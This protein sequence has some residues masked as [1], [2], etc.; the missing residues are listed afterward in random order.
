MSGPIQKGI[1][2]ALKAL[3]NAKS[4]T[5][6]LLHP[7]PDLSNWENAV[8]LEAQFDRVVK[9]IRS[10]EMQMDSLRDSSNAWIEL[11]ARLIG[12][13]KDNGEKEYVKFD[14]NEKIAERYDAATTKLRDLRDLEATLS[15]AAKLHKGRA[16]REAKA[17]QL[18]NPQQQAPMPPAM[19]APMAAPTFTA[20]LYQFQPI[21]LDKFFGQK[22]KW[23]EF[24]ESFKSAIGSQSISKAQKLN[25]LLNLLGGEAREL[26]AGF[27]LEDA[28]YET[29]LQLLKDTYGAPEEHIRSLH[30]ELANLKPCRGLRET[31]DFL[32]QL[33]R[34]TRELNN[35]GEDIEGPQVFLMLEKKLTPA[36]LRNILN[37]KGEDPANWTTTKFRD[38][39]N[40]A[41][42]KEVQIQEVLGEYGHHHQSI[43]RPARPA[44]QAQAPR[45][46][47]FAANFRNRN[48]TPAIRERTFMS[49]TIEEVHKR[50]NHNKPQLRKSQPRG[51]RPTQ[52]PSTVP[53][54]NGTA[55]QAGPRKPPS[56]CLFCNGNHWNEECQR[57]NTVQQRSAFVRDKGLCF[58]CL[59]SNHRASEC[60]RPIKCYK[61]RQ[62]HPAILCQEGT[63]AATQ[64]Q[65]AAAVT[66]RH[67]NQDEQKSTNPTA[68]SMSNAVQS[69][70]TRALL[71]TTMATIFNP[72]RP[73]Q[74]M[75][76]TVF[77]DPG[78]H[79]SFISN[80]AAKQLELTVLRTEECFLTSFGEREPKRYVS[81]RVA[82][83]FL[84]PNGDRLI[85]NLNALKFLLNNLPVLQLNTLDKQQLQQKKLFP[86]HESRQPDVMLGMDVWHDLHV[87]PIERLPSGFTIC[88]SKIGKIISGTGRIELSQPSNV[89]FVLTVT[90]ENVFTTEEDLK[91]NE[92]LNKFYGLNII[93]M[94]DSSTP[95]DRDEVMKNF[96]EN[97]SFVNNKYQIALPWND[98]VAQ[99]PTNY[100][101]AKAR[102]ISLIR[103]LRTIN[104]VDEYQ[105]ILDEQQQNSIIELVNSDHSCGPVHYLPHR[106]VIR[107]D[108]STT[109]IRIVMDASA[110]PKSTP[111]APSLNECL[112]TGPLLLK[113]LTGI[114]LRF[115]RMEKVILADIEKAFLQLGVREQDRDATRFLWLA[116]P[117]EANLEQL[118]REDFRVFRFCR[119]S[120]GLTV[121]PFLLNATLRE[122]LALYDTDVAQR[123]SDNLY[124]DNIMMEVTPSENITQLITEAKIIFESAGMRIREFFGSHIDEL[125]ELDSS[126]LA[127][128][129]ENT[130]VL[131]IEWKP[132]HDQ[133]IFKMPIFSSPTTKRKILSHIAKVYDPL[134]L[135]SPAL[136]P[137]KHF[138]QIVQN[139]NFKWDDP[140]PEKMALDWI[141]LMQAW[142]GFGFNFR[143]EFPRHIATSPS[144]EFHCFCDASKSGLGV[145]LYQLADTSYGKKES[146]LI[147]GKS[148]V[149][150]LKVADHDSTIPK[151][152]LQALTLGVKVTKF[153]Q[154][155]LNFNDQQVVLWTDSQCS[156]ERLKEERKYDRFVSNRLKKIREARFKVMHIRTDENPA[157]IASRGTDPQSL[158]SSLL[159]RFGPAW[160]TKVSQWPESNVTY[161]PGEE[162]REVTEPPIVEWS[163][164]VQQREEFVPAIQFERFSNWNRLRATAAHVIRFAVTMLQKRQN[165][166]PTNSP[167]LTHGYQS[168][169]GPLTANE[170]EIADE[171]MLIE[172]QLQHWPSESVINN[173]KL[174][175]SKPLE[176]LKCQG[177]LG[178]ANLPIQSKN[179]IFLPAEAWT[180][181]L[182]IVHYDRI[183]KHCGPRILLSKIR[184]K[185]WI[186]RG[187]QTVQNALYSSRIGCLAC[188]KEKLKPYAYP[189]APNL[190]KER[191][192]ETRPF[193]NTGI[194]YF[195]PLK[196]KR[197]PETVKVYV[198]LFTCLVI[199]AIH[200]EVADDYSAEAF[201]RVFRRFAAR[202]GVPRVILSDQGTNFIAGAKVIKENWTTDLLTL[203]VQEQLAHQGITWNFNTAHAPWKGGTWER[204]I[205]ITKNA[206][207]RSIGRRLL[208]FDEFGTLVVEIEA[209]VNHRPLTFESDREPDPVLRPV[210]FLIPYGSTETNFP[211]M[212]TDPEDPEYQP[213]PNKLK[214]MLQKADSRLNS[215][216][217]IWRSEYLLSLRE[218]AN[219]RLNNEQQTPNEGDIVLVEEE[220]NPR[221]VWSLARVLKVQIGRDNKSRSALISHN[222]KEKWR[223]VNQLYSLEIQPE[224]PE[225][226]FT[227]FVMSN[228][229]ND[230]DSVSLAG[231]E[232]E[233]PQPKN[234]FRIPKRKRAFLRPIPQQHSPLQGP[235]RKRREL[236]DSGL[237]K[238]F[239]AISE[240]EGGSKATTEAINESRAVE[241]APPPVQKEF[242][243]KMAKKQRE[244]A[245]TK[246]SD[247]LKQKLADLP[248]APAQTEAEK[249]EQQKE[250]EIHDQQRAE[251]RN[252]AEE[253]FKKPSRKEREEA[254]SFWSAKKAESMKEKTKGRPI[255]DMPK[256]NEVLLAYCQRI[257]GNDNWQFLWKNGR[258]SRELHQLETQGWTLHDQKGKLVEPS[259][260]LGGTRPSMN[261]RFKEGHYTNLTPEEMVF[262][263]PPVIE[264]EPEPE[265]IVME[266]VSSSELQE[267][268]ERR[269]QRAGHTPPPAP[270]IPEPEEL[271]IECYQQSWPKGEQYVGYNILTECSG[272]RHES[273]AKCTYQQIASTR[274]KQLNGFEDCEANSL[275]NAMLFDWVQRLLNLRS[276]AVILHEEYVMPSML[277]P[278]Q[279]AEKFWNEHFI[280]KNRQL[281]K[282]APLIDLLK[283]W[284]NSCDSFG[285]LMQLNQ[286]EP[287]KLRPISM[288]GNEATE[289][290][291]W[292]ENLNKFTANVASRTKAA[293][294]NQHYSNHEIICV[295][296]LA[297]EELANASRTQ[298]FT[299]YASDKLHLSPGPDV[300]HIIFCYLANESDLAKGITPYVRELAKTDIQLTIVL[301]KTEEKTWLKNKNECYQ[302]AKAAKAGFFVYHRRTGE[303]RQ[304]TDMI[305]AREEDEIME[306]DPTPSTSAA[307]SSGLM[308][309][310]TINMLM[311][312]SMFGLL[313]LQ[314]TAAAPLRI[315]R[316][317]LSQNA[318]RFLQMVSAHYSTLTTAPPFELT[319]TLST[320]LPPVTSSWHSTVTRTEAT[321]STMPSPWTTTTWTP[322]TTTRQ[323]WTPTTS[324]STRT[325]RRTRIQYVTRARSQQTDATTPPGTIKSAKS[326]KRDLGTNRDGADVFWCS[327]RGSTIWELKGP[328]SSPFCRPPPSLTAEWH[329]L[330]IELYAKSIRPEQIG[331][332]WHCSI[333]RTTENYYTNLLGDK[334]VTIVKEFPPVNKR[335]CKQ[336]ALHQECPYATSEMTN[337]EGQLWSTNDELNVNFP[338]PISGLFKGEQTSTATN[339]FVQPATVFIK[340]QTLQMLSPVHQ[341]QNCQYSAEFC[342][343][344]DNTTL[345]WKSTCSGDECKMCDYEQAEIIS[346]KFTAS[347]GETVATWIS[348]DH[349]KALTFA[350]K[351]PEL[352]A[353]DGV[354]I[355]LSEQNFGITK[356]QYDDIVSTTRR[357]KRGIRPE[358]LA[359]Q[360]SAS[361]VAT[362]VALNQ[363]YIR[364]CQRNS[365]AANPTLQARKLLRQANI[366]ARW[367]GETTMEVFPCVNISLQ[368]ISYRPMNDCRLYI[369]VTAHF[370]DRAIA[371]FLDPELRIISLTAQQASCNSY[372]FHHLQLRSNP[373][374]WLWI[375]TRT[376]TARRMPND[377]VHELYETTINQT[378]SNLELHP[379]IFHAW[380]LD[381]ESDATRFPHINEFINSELFKEKL[382]QHVTA[383]TEALGALKGGIEG[384]TV[385]WL[386]SLVDEAITWWIR[387]AC[388]YS[389]FL[390]LRDIIL[391]CLLAYLLNPIRV[392]L[393]SL[394]GVRQH[395]KLRPTVSK[396]L[397]IEE[398]MPLREMPRTPKSPAR[399]AE[400]RS[401]SPIKLDMIARTARYQQPR[402]QS[403]LDLTEDTPFGRPRRKEF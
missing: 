97:L 295:G 122:H 152:E 258:T 9:E 386:K 24:Y 86:P 81:D 210:N 199:R 267:E 52:A 156:I 354:R 143:V 138:L 41:V 141:K 25:L 314:P 182:I 6:L 62:L 321:T 34:L 36:F 23:P 339:C 5:S 168:E 31:K 71:M 27:R 64:S 234:R 361:Q 174:F 309:R 145:A 294:A 215:F 82:I 235:R 233:M 77:I 344:P 243:Q 102:L 298:W 218:R 340:R 142:E 136:L 203:E 130:K 183:H 161:N 107:T 44:T 178:N 114:L 255:E 106:A 30:F 129:L 317:S 331:S 336:M 148:H 126:E 134:G 302:L 42:R 366:Q 252:E 48:A 329:N 400:H 185:F 326:A 277:T 83:G 356:D 291:N 398:G 285:A 61:C 359:S 266:D 192:N 60:P 322:I 58:K 96:K 216:W 254:R 205:G 307:S 325:T 382:E 74:S 342:Q 245:R 219:Q 14:K 312:I 280:A 363:L 181:K 94:D 21:Q 172:T 29:V 167:L 153:V 274:K 119:V 84:C 208:T 47:N 367:I 154:T 139:L 263:G 166:E 303:A 135:I 402:T 26:I 33:E 238:L 149:K 187:R 341:V 89:T 283:Q 368:D 372:R 355:V 213:N 115:R 123:I 244:K 111:S 124:V 332:A 196:V 253:V 93:G 357:W 358:Q 279:L 311:L 146:N 236:Q 250:R 95:I 211:S 117:K 328:E 249:E 347:Y 377:Y 118:K 171:W 301:A 173:L 391:P 170:L 120:F 351:A 18:A 112:H 392:T 281:V 28:N 207:R 12:D 338:G 222:G 262:H 270:H 159:W 224:F 389:T 67:P 13:D 164:A 162:I 242:E 324:A 393:L 202:R 43:D 260:F 198:A 37:K 360:L 257:Y 8:N 128:D 2:N 287:I 65:Q 92:E 286:F 212:A 300:Q 231:S 378:N 75:M 121:S 256:H 335:I 379:L 19:A 195:G 165:P 381:N 397:G 388:V 39:L 225:T 306:I 228:L 318:Q 90:D 137:A 327:D 151:L 32:L 175:K 57:Y 247:R 11:L 127:K 87:Q 125:K 53:I 140:L 184:E 401:M 241:K 345:I 158:Q 144:E 376:G 385:R 394:V 284:S 80:T 248:R 177:R 54:R 220:A 334:F 296:D 384:F 188:K 70:D 289:F 261:V 292:L 221:S 108:K 56:P 304:L 110:K 278:K 315:H 375:D 66:E 352:I 380:Q 176:T 369:P 370:P 264:S 282:Q 190:P 201:L 179:P 20:P 396:P 305:L 59:K 131:G 200:L 337:H 276:E 73:C 197:G 269:V 226:H 132:R 230:I 387:V 348:D 265:I 38:V 350:K 186:P 76:A 40:E 268:N 15:A 45:T 91:A 101:Q 4:A 69:S 227:T 113:D 193:N 288:E 209:I 346:G 232:D 383:R 17:D 343:L 191:V 271:R 290:E 194:D 116:K 105:A 333:K 353:C 399:R 313:F 88:Q 299:H 133:L 259:E 239:C 308:S 103:K 16:D 237:R 35:A 293:I 364:E 362:S 272:G 147:F 374:I 246:T 150:P 251:R 223:A 79:R 72:S 169:K 160:L 403:H 98:R 100:H 371:A 63:N 68:Q 22:R 157:D 78:S 273:C 204:L 1:I 349:Q 297:A 240:Q 7:D 163:N 189:E 51:L 330:A 50:V 99:L 395:P 323:R 319:S 275:M 49:S 55:I 46:R 109:K 180:T 104:L 206:L 310:N 229:D 320:A 365:R 3:D 390:M 214:T 316:A 373:N 10:M 85:F 217:E 155:Q